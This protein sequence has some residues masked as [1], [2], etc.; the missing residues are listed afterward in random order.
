VCCRVSTYCSQAG[1]DADWKAHKKLGKEM[2]GKEEGQTR[3]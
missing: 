3:G 2:I 1:I